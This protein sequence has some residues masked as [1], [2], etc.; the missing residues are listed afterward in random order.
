M[1]TASRRFQDAAVRAHHV[2]RR[3]AHAARRALQPLQIGGQDRPDIGADRGR[4]GALEL[5]DLRQHLA[6]TDRSAR[7]G[8]AARRR[9]PSRRSCSGLRKLNSSET[10]IASHARRLQRRDQ[11]VDLALGERRDDGAVGADALGD[12]EA[13]AARDQRGRRVLEQVVEVGARRAPQ[14]Q[15]VAE[16]ARGDERGARALLLQDGV[17][18]DGGGVRQQ[19]DLGRRRRRSAAS[20]MSS[21]A[22]TPS[23]RSRG[24]VGTLA[25]PM[26]PARLVDQR[27][28]RERAAD[29]D[30]DPPSHVALCPD[31]ARP[32]L[33]GFGAARQCARRADRTAIPTLRLNP[34]PSLHSALSVA[35]AASF[36]RRVFAE[37]AEQIDD[38]LGRANLLRCHITH[39]DEYP[40]KNASE[41][42]L[43]HESR[44]A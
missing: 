43:P 14:L 30:P 1:A 23:A 18:D 17:G 15:H 24:V 21:A 36:F 39:Q 9:A 41:F 33:A 8:S 26:L 16:A 27:H 34:R 29:V 7:P 44:T 19:P 12:L 40:A 25:T 2:E 37:R 3:Q 6:T 13:A 20:P 38:G 28:V 5:L 31:A 22:S 11:A 42:D 35:V 4:A 32:S 10:A